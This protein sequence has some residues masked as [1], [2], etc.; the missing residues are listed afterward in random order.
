MFR[1]KYF[2]RV[3]TVSGFVNSD[4]TYV[5]SPNVPP[6]SPVPPPLIFC[7]GAGYL[8]DSVIDGTS[9]WHKL[10]METLAKYFTVF[11]SDFDST[12]TKGIWGCDAH[13]ALIEDARTYLASTMG[14]TG[15][16]TL[17][18][19]SMGGLGVMNYAKNYPGNVKTLAPITAVIDLQ[20]WWSSLTVPA[21]AS[22]DAVYPPN[23][24]DATY[25]ANYNPKLWWSSLTKDIFVKLF[26]STADQ[27]PFYN[28]IGSMQASRPS[29]LAQNYAGGHAEAGLPYMFNDVVDFCLR[30]GIG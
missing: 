20:D 29:T 5:L 2:T 11:V 6:S 9:P 21:R 26:Y 19:V 8:L 15:K 13:V 30:P 23:Y 27:P 4:K 10:L 25:G 14:S 18:G 1:S 24:S 16:V 28:A 22:I 7:H 17:V 12:Q 3:P